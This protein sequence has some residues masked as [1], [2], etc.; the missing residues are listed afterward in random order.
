MHVNHWPACMQDYTHMC[1]PPVYMY[2]QY[3]HIKTLCYSITV[4]KGFIATEKKDSHIKTCFL[5]IDWKHKVERL[6]QSREV[7]VASS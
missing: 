3:T 4:H 1:V 6:E 2:T 5:S 7:W